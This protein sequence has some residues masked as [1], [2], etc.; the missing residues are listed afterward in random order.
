MSGNEKR[1]LINKNYYE[2][3]KEERKRA[4]ELKKQKDIEP[5]LIFQETNK[6]LINNKIAQEKTI[7]DKQIADLQT[8]IDALINEKKQLFEKQ[9]T[10]PNQIATDL[11]INHQKTASKIVY[12]KTTAKI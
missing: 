10:L 2:K 5:F 8:K 9:S 1:K 6:D 7:I 4:R 3:N 11:F 12:G